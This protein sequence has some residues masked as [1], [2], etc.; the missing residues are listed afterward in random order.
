MLKLCDS[1]FERILAVTSSWT[2]I[3]PC[4][5]H[6]VPVLISHPTDVVQVALANL[7][8]DVQLMVHPVEKLALALPKMCR[9]EAEEPLGVLCVQTDHQKAASTAEQRPD[10]EGDAIDV[11]AVHATAESNTYQ[12]QHAGVHGSASC[13]QA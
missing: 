1:F 12:H 13:A 6:D 4:I 7:P 11:E 8:H 9:R 5:M 2:V 10:E 3:V